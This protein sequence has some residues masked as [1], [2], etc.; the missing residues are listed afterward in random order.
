MEIIY[1]KHYHGCRPTYLNDLHFLLNEYV[2]INVGISP[3]IMSFLVNEKMRKLKL[4]F[5]LYKL[6]KIILPLFK[7]T[8]LTQQLIKHI[9][10]GDWSKMWNGLVKITARKRARIAFDI[11][12]GIKKLSGNYIEPKVAV[13]NWH[14]EQK[15]YEE[16]KEK[17]KYNKTPSSIKKTVDH[18]I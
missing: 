5:A 3:K 1:R 14:D 10:K 13:S 6:L 7:T 11:S 17:E 18:H 4:S 16:N 15:E 9:I 8:V 12:L 2:T